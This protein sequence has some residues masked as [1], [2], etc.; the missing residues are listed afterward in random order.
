[1]CEPMRRKEREHSLYLLPALSSS[2]CRF[3][4]WTD[5]SYVAVTTPVH[6][7][8]E[9]TCGA[10]IPT[11][12]TAARAAV[13]SA[14]PLSRLLS[15]NRKKP[16]IHWKGCRACS[17][18]PDL[19]LL[20]AADGKSRSHCQDTVLYAVADAAC[21]FYTALTAGPCISKGHRSFR[22]AWPTQT[23]CK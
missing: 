9:G 20:P 14:H 17:A 4:R 3:Q 1:M 22:P 5:S 23:I 2:P 8:V 15:A 16:C 7:L 18:R 12:H 19:I 21:S 11:I 13:P 6:L 10:P